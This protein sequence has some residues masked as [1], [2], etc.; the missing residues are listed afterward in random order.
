MHNNFVKNVV[1]TLKTRP[2]LHAIRTTAQPHQFYDLCDIVTPDVQ[3]R[4]NC[5]YSLSGPVDITTIFRTRAHVVA[6]RDMFIVA[7]NSAKGA[8]TSSVTEALFFVSDDALETV[9][10]YLV[11]CTSS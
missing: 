8:L 10:E 1:H 5:L 2:D 9:M 7:T 4:T 11:G 6:V 3:E